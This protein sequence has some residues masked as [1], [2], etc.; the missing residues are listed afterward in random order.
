MGVCIAA[1][2]EHI[3]I[4]HLYGGDTTEGAIDECVRH[5]V[6]KMSCLHLVSTKEAQKRVIQLGENPDT[7]HNVGSLGVENVLNQPLMTREELSDS[8]GFSLDKGFAVVTFHPVTL[9]SG[10]AKLQCEEL[11]KALDAFP[12]LS[13]IITKANADSEGLLINKL[14]ENYSNIRK[15]VILVDSLGMRRYLSAISMSEMVIG[16]S[17]S[18]LVEVPSFHVPTVNIGNR[19][20]GRLRPESV[21][22]C[23][24]TA[25]DIIAAM[26]LA[27][28]DRFKTLCMNCVNPYGNG[29]TTEEIVRYIDELLSNTIDLKKTFYD[30]DYEV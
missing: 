12:D 14:L 4:I 13:F 24:N 5:S 3:P 19:Q 6:T 30:I 22:D 10:Q 20:K 16:N 17:S 21:I 29:R 8:L 15:N 9:E 1:M 11:I 26:K 18:G 7:V 23:N 27:Q 28:S 2:N 25:E